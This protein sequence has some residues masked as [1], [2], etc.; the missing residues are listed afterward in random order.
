MTLTLPPKGNKAAPKKPQ[1]GPSHDVT[2]ADLLDG[3]VDINLGTY[4]LAGWCTQEGE[5]LPVHTS[6]N[7]A[8]VAR[9]FA[10]EALMPAE[11]TE[12]AL[13]LERLVAAHFD[14]QKTK[15]TDALPAALRTALIDRKADA[16][17]PPLVT[18][19]FAGAAPT[20]K[21]W[22]DLRAVILH[23]SRI[24]EYMALELNVAA[25]SRPRRS[26]PETVLADQSLVHQL[27]VEDPVR[28]ILHQRG[29]E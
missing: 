6:V 14:A 2:A 27:V 13:R 24:F 5:I 8:G 28:D 7:A 23:L 16:D 1:A 10:R 26:E 20:F 4:F 18:Q 15:W 22:A 11:A 9:A 17:E 25:A 21:R 19:W 3:G 12:M 29:D